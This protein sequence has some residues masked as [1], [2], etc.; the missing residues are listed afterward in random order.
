MG[1][2]SVIALLPLFAL[3]LAAACNDGAVR[4]FYGDNT[5]KRAHIQIPELTPEEAG[6][7]REMTEE[8][9]RSLF[10]S[11]SGDEWAFIDS[12]VRSGATVKVG[13]VGDAYPASFYNRVEKKYQ[14]IAPEILAEVTSLTGIEFDME[15]AAPHSSIAELLQKLKAGEYSIVTQV[16]YS[17]SRKD[18]YL[19]SEISYLSSKYALLSKIDFPKVDR[20]RVPYYRVGVIERSTHAE[21]FDRWFPG[22]RYRVSYPTGDAAFNALERGE[23]DLVMVSESMLWA[24]TNY[25]EKTGYKVNVSFDEKQESRLGYHRDEERLRDIIDKV[26]VYI[27]VEGIRDNWMIRTFDYSRKIAQ[28]RMRYAIAIAVIAVAAVLILIMLLVKNR[29]LSSRLFFE[30]QMHKAAEARAVEASNVKSRFL[31]NMSHEIRTPLNAIVGMSELLSMEQLSSRQQGYLKD[32]T[33]ASHSLLSIINDILDISKIEAGKFELNSV[34]FDFYELLANISSMF[35]LMARKKGIDFICELDRDGLPKYLYGDDVR[36]R[37]IIINI[38]ANAVNFTFRGYVRLKIS[39]A[40]GNLVFEVRDT[41][42]GIKPEDQKDLFKPFARAEQAKHRESAGTGLGL[43][44]SKTFAEMMNGSITVESEYGEGST[45]TVTI[46]LAIG[47]ESKAR[48]AGRKNKAAFK[49]P[50]AR[51]LVVDDNDL[52]LK[53]AF[54]LLGLYRITPDMVTS[55]VGAIRSVQKSNYQIVF[56]DHMMPGMDGIEATNKIRALGEEY[57]KLPIIA[58]TANATHG[59]R[60]IFLESGMDDYLSKP[61]ELDTLNDILRKWLPAEMIIAGAQDTP[62]A[63]Q[64]ER[65]RRWD[66]VAAVGHINVEVGRNRVAG[67][68]EV[69]H[70]TLELFCGRLAGERQ[71]LEKFLND[72]DMDNFAILIHGMKS[73]LATI[74]AMAMSERAREL[75]DA[76]KSGNRELCLQKLPSLLNDLQELGAKLAPICGFEEKKEADRPKGDAIILE[77]GVKAALNAAENYDGDKCIDIIDKLQQYDFGEEAN[78]MLKNTK[79]AVKNFDFEE[80]VALLRL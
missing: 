77:K 17:E 50:N 21:M 27:D 43:P 45:F 2:K 30:S 42:P 63:E 78:E 14:G 40:G 11:L 75:E 68:W 58:L 26:M 4:S 49:A 38:C 57:K 69:Y 13:V 47:D 61:I 51:I 59:V 35:R 22:H 3:L 66:D 32:I 29:R 72:G 15:A 31:A 10:S 74:G 46:P 60:E 23:V 36:L 64:D 41:G 79:A 70:E 24:L 53:V 52:N 1:A 76:S 33:L 67:I 54:R 44:I 20:Y 7:I 37:Q 8:R 18:D 56:M 16:L 80:T 65:S 55:G 19:W 6:A 71:K 25:R 73:S 48:A 62:E 39:C 12:L 9:K 5:K 28:E 34:D